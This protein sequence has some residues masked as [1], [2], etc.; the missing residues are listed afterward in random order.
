MTPYI[1]QSPSQCSG[2]TFFT[3]F[4]ASDHTSHNGSGGGAVDVFQLL[5]G[6]TRNESN[7]QLVLLNRCL[8]ISMHKTVFF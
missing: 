4:C 1:Y 5:K 7:G 6:L 8:L 3:S 2:S